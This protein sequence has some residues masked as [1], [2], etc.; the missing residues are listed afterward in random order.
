MA[1]VSVCAA[2]TPLTVQLRST[3][4]SPQ[5][6]GTPIGL[7]ALPQG[8]PPGRETFVFQYSISVNGGPFHVV[9]DYSQQFAFAWTPDLFE[10]SATIRVKVRDN[11]TKATGQAEMPFQ[12]VS[13]VKDKA[14]A[15]P[16]SHPLVALF[17]A[18]PCP[19]GSQFRVAFHA[20]GE[21]AISRTPA[22]PCRGSISSNVYVA[23]MRAD[24]EYQLRSE[25]TTGG[26]VTA[27]HYL[28]IGR[29]HV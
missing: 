26:S 8:H 12:F 14:V 1:A 23:G 24:T 2:E 11:D 25:V 21:E 27:G 15:T 10:Q 6:V 9:H 5:P 22:Q 18:P 7:T 28:Q 17:S 20:D 29:A 16:T 3:L 19:M 13:R 4:A